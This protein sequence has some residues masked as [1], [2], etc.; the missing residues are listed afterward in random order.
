VKHLI[1]PKGK[2]KLLI[3]VPTLECGGLERNVVLICDHIDTTKYDV[4]L[5]VLN[6]AN[7]FF[8]VSNAGVK[9][10]DLQI[11]NVRKSLFTLMR[12]SKK[13]KPD[14]ILSTANHLNLFF[15]IFRSLF[16]KR[17]KFI[18]RESSIVSMNNE[19]SFS[20]AL[21]HWLCRV[22]YKK[23][24]MIVCQSKYMQ[25]DLKAHY[26]IKADRTCIINNAVT[27]PAITSGAADKSTYARLITVARL[28]EEKGLDRLI[29][30]VSLL[31]IPY[32]FTIIG[33]GAMRKALEQLITERSLTEKVF[34]PG[35]SDTPFTV[36]PHADLFLMGSHYEGFPNAMLEAMAAGIP[37]VAFDAPGGIAEL[38]VNDKNG[39]LVK[40]DSESA[41]AMAI[42]K[43]IG[44]GFD[45]DTI[46]SETIRRFNVHAIIKQW[47]DLFDSLVVQKNA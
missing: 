44:F 17:I 32:R 38:M 26:N 19:R 29:K 46:R 45:H 18:A 34:L 31:K 12:L 10:I 9:V 16:S 14:I 43:A 37:V 41:F 35:R 4:T 11:P 2:L 13:L 24:D 7:P 3:V 27:E 8:T 5:A 1:Q 30:A 42:E 15:A 39:I 25:D 47:Y 23:I 33:E 40:D 6:N 28:S 20:P 21:F 22:F 36:V